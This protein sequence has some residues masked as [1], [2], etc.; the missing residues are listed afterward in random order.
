MNIGVLG[1]LKQVQG[2]KMK[3][4]IFTKLQKKKVRVDSQ[5]LSEI[6]GTQIRSA[7]LVRIANQ[8]FATKS[9]S[10]K[11]DEEVERLQKP[12][13]KKK[14]PRKDRS[15]KRM[16]VEDKD[17]DKDPDLNTKDMS[18]NYKIVGSQLERVWFRGA[19]EDLVTVRRKDDGK[20]VQ[21]SEKTLEERKSEFDLVEN[22]DKDTE[23]D[24]GEKKQPTKEDVRKKLK[25]EPL[26]TQDDLKELE[27]LLDLIEEET[28]EQDQKEFD[29]EYDRI[30][31]ERKEEKQQAEEQAK[32]E[33]E[34]QAKKEI[35]EKEVGTKDKAQQTLNNLV[36]NE[37][38]LKEFENLLKDISDSELG[39]LNEAL[40]DQKKELEELAKKIESSEDEKEIEELKKEYQDKEALSSNL[41]KVQDIISVNAILRGLDTELDDSITDQ[42]KNLVM[43]LGEHTDTGSLSIQKAMSKLV[44]VPEGANDDQKEINSKYQTRQAIKEL[45]ENKTLDEKMDILLSKD[46]GEGSNLKES[47]LAYKKKLDNP[48]LS[49]SKRKELEDLANSMFSTAMAEALTLENNKG[50][51][52]NKDKKK[53]TPKSK[54]EQQ[55]MRK[56]FLDGVGK[57]MENLATFIVENPDTEMSSLTDMVTE[58]ISNQ[59]IIQQLQTRIDNEENPEIKRTLQE[60]MKQQ[61]EQ[62]QRTAKIKRNLV[63]AWGKI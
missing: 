16:K 25:E 17:I 62:I 60:Q 24:K 32:K 22:E 39:Y 21:V 37:N 52:K 11:E 48:S 58:D 7:T 2:C 3:E 59:A 53:E 36:G 33:K 15:R 57:I 6:A 27:D 54:K 9:Q 23:S 13:P 12:S 63:I 51:S 18:M 20:V 38:A 46:L 45:T 14:P 5:T 49:K 40:Q 34:E 31:A 56:K 47:F 30:L 44:A 4:Q 19:K 1:I 35:E 42:Q 41:S 50:S 8:V 26:L 61:Q 10:E 43:F 28:K 55:E 29:A